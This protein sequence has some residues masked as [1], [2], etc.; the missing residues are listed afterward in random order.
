[1]DQ[2]NNEL[3]DHTRFNDQQNR[4]YGLLQIWSIGT[5]LMTKHDK[6]IQQSTTEVWFIFGTLIV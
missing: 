3:T 2:I 4:Q 1:M 6:W 5:I